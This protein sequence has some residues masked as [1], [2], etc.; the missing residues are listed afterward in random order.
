M[1]QANQENNVALNIW[2]RDREIVLSRVVAAPRELVFKVWTDPEHLPKWFGPEGFGVETLEIDIRVGGRWRFI[3]WGPDG[4]R[5]D[6]RMVF[7]KVDA[8][9]LLEMDHGSD[10][11]NDPGR[12]RVIVTFDEQN[13]GKTV[14]TLRQLHPTKEQREATIGFG[15]VEFG[16]QT[17]DKLVRHVAAMQNA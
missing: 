11:D 7:L 14:V 8:P 3:F 9:Q 5:Y 13:D 1:T 2:S 17:L 10:K 6:N 15:A 16:Y 4:K 12:F